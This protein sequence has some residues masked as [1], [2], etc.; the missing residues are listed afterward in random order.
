[1]RREAQ[2]ELAEELE[3]VLDVLTGSIRKHVDLFHRLPLK[4][5]RWVLLS[6][7][8]SRLVSLTTI[9]VT[10]S[11]QNLVTAHD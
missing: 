10:I 2:E 5:E 4:P 11:S 3:S 7:G 9:I 8:S 1:M 6:H